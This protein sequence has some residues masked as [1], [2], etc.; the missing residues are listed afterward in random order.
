MNKIEI[1]ITKDN[2][3]QILIKSESSD[4]TIL[5]GVIIN[6]DELYNLYKD[7]RDIFSNQ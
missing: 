7:L 6:K 1:N 2:K 4:I 5:N 3:Y